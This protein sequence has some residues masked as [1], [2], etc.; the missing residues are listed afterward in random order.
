LDDVEDEEEEGKPSGEWKKLLVRPL[1][2]FCLSIPPQDEGENDNTTVVTYS[3]MIWTTAEFRKLFASKGDETMFITLMIE[4]ANQ[5][6]KQSKIPVCFV[7]SYSVSTLPPRYALI[8]RASKNIQS[9]ICHR[10][11]GH[12]FRYSKNPRKWLSSSTVRTLQCCLLQSLSRRVYVG[13]HG[14][15]SLPVTNGSRL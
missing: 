10:R 4:E 14:Q 9:R 8:F 12:H 7:Q 13:K 5:G 15:A 11:S 1:R 3:V 2:S 6:Y